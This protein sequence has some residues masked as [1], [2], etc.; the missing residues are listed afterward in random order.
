MVRVDVFVNTAI[1]TMWC[2]N[3]HQVRNGGRRIR[4]GR[5]RMRNAESREQK[6]EGLQQ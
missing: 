6:T 4:R 3:S 5:E 1:I 2:G